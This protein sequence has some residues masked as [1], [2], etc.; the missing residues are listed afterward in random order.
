MS[1]R[2]IVNGWVIPIDSRRPYIEDGAVAIEADRIVAVG[3][4]SE[5]RQAFTADETID[6]RGKAILPGFINTHIHLIGAVNK[7][8]TEDIPGVSGGLFKVAMPLHF[9]YLEPPDVYWLACMHALEMLKTGTTTA[10]EIGRFEREVA[11]AVRDTGLRTP[12][13]HPIRPQQIISN[14]VY[15]ANGSDITHV[16]VDGQVVVADA[17]SV[18]VDEVVAYREC[19]HAA[20]VVWDRAREIFDA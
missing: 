17:V 5:I 10:N 12:W 2:L 14:I 4:T 6:A 1:T 13:L 15:N 7:G 18:V 11:K 19:Q 20:N 16:I 8:L 9:K 3:P